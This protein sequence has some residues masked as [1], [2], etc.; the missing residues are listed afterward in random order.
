MSLHIDTVADGAALAERAADLLQAAAQEGL[1]QRGRF[2]IALAGGSTPRQCYQRW[3]QRTGLDWA[4]GV[5]VFGDER[6]V[7]PDWEQSN[8]RMVR[9]ALLSHLPVAPRVLRMEGETPVPGAA[10]DRYDKA[11]RDLL[12]NEG[13]L[14]LALLGIGEDGHTASLFP[15]QPTLE[16][17]TQW[18]VATEKPGEPGMD[19]QRLTLTFPILRTARHI[20]FLSSGAGKAEIVHRVLKG[21]YDPTLLPAQTLLRNDKLP[22]TLVVD[23]AAAAKLPQS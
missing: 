23:A 1:Q 2:V 16:E 13:R 20:V 4:R 14:D 3:A 19:A 12:G 15:E 17:A 22:Q 7:P 8:F 6:C 21:P 11:L 10:A 18:C 9:E 5:L